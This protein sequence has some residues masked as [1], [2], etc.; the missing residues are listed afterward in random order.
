MP[1]RG[2]DD[3]QAIGATVDAFAA[4]LGDRASHKAT[5]SRAMNLFARSGMS[6]AAFI[7]VLY[8]AKG[9]VRDRHQHPGNA[10]L[11]RNQMAY[12]FAVV[13]DRLGERNRA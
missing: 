9:E 1:K 12:F 4:E 11:P 5:V 10:P 2:G 6:R 3:Q 13:E 8:Q 7:D